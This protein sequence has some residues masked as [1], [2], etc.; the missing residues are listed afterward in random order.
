[1]EKKS[2]NCSLHTAVFVA[3]TNGTLARGW[4]NRVV[5]AT[6]YYEAGV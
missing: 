5:N 6:Q 3:V 4:P 2:W 1:M